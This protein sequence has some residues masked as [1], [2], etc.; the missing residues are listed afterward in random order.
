VMSMRLTVPCRS[1]FV[2]RR[3]L[4]RSTRAMPIIYSL[5]ARQNDVLVEETVDGMTGNFPVL[6]RSLLKVCVSA[7]PSY[8]AQS[9][10]SRLSLDAASS[11]PPVSVE[12]WS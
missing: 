2:A 7:P 4:L 1:L 10:C 5:I 11:P 12:N 3:R 8:R 6:T 9:L